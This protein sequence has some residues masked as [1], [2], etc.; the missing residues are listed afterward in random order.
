M[1]TIHRALNWF[2]PP[3]VL[4]LLVAGCSTAPTNFSD[5]PQS[6][7]S[8]EAE[9]GESRLV[10]TNRLQADWLRPATNLFTLGPGDRLDVEL[11]GETNSLTQT[12]VCPDGKVYFNV[13]QGVDVWGMTLGEA[14][15]LIEKKLAEQIRNGPKV[16]VSLR[17]AQSKR[18]WLL[19]RVQAPGVYPLTHPTTLLEALAAAGGTSS[20]VSQRDIPLS[21]AVEELA[22]LRRSFIVRRGMLLPVDFERLLN[23]GDLSQNIY[24]QPDDF[25][26][27]PP[28]TAPQVYVIGA[29]GQPRS[30]DYTES[31]TLAGAIA[32]AYGTVKDAYLSHV[33]VVRGSFAQ[34]EI[35]VVNFNHVQRGKRPDVDLRP[36]DI[37]YVPYSPYRYLVKYLETVLNTFAA[38]VAINAGSS[39]V[40]RQ[41][42]EQGVFIPVGSRITVQPPLPPVH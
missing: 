15:G 10:L 29:V 1:S 37:V 22:D 39:L 17:T 2:I 7:K 12:V 19:G 35:N 42:S 34:P 3:F 5:L 11:I 40:L 38:S 24:L 31:L 27:L 9:E 13:L 20:Y 32:G 14:K 26:Y 28:A 23:H 41:P 18:V 30:V 33:A 21:T 25:I 6:F 36:G 4:L 8:E 16:A